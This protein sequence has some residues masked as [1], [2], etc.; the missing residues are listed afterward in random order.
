[1]LLVCADDY[2]IGPETSRGLLELAAAGRIDAAV[3]LVNNPYAADAVK[4]WRRTGPSAELGWHP[5]LTLDGPVLPAREVASLVDSDGRFWPLPAFMKRWALGRLR[6]EHI[7]AE[8]FAQLGRFRELVGTDPAIVNAHQHVAVFEPVGTI[9][10]ELLRNVR[11]F[12]RRVRERR[13]TLRQ[14]AAARLKRIFLTTLARTSNRAFDRAHCPGNDTLAGI[15]DHGDVHDPEFYSRWLAR[16][17]GD[18]VE[19]MVHP[20]HRD[21]TL[22]GRDCVPGDGCLERHVREQW[23]LE[24]DA[25]SVAVAAAGF[26]RVTPRELR[27]RRALAG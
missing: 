24:Q 3:L 14:I 25:F 26:R 21:E 4:N 15:A 8:L 13:V 1:M 16:A 5:C 17:P 27:G 6:P 23:L 2:G 12:V 11:P 9:L 22:V 18:V 19:L 20:G 7:T 10:A